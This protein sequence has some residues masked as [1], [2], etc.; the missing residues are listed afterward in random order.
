M[1]EQGEGALVELR[2]RFGENS[3]CLVPCDV[4]SEEQFSN[5]LDQAEKFFHVDCV[6][7]LV[8]NAG[9]FTHLGWRR[10]IDV[11]LIGTMIGTQLAMKRMR[12]KPKHGYQ[13]INTSSSAAFITFL[14]EKGAAYHM[15]KAG[16]LALTRSMAM[17]YHKHGVVTKCLC[18]HVTDTAFVHDGLKVSH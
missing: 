11:T 10:C 12:G 16:V 8:N 4:T 7:V 3:V 9:I 2:E 18:P 13:I 14:E 1:G 17:D 15:A 5:L 6:D